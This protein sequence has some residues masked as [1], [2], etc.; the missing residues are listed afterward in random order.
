MGVC[1]DKA[2]RRVTRDGHGVAS[3]RH[4]RH[5]VNDLLA[6]FVLIQVCK[7]AGPAVGLAQLQRPPG[8]KA[9]RQELDDH[10]V[11]AHAIL[12]VSIFPGFA[13]RHADFFYMV[14]DIQK[15]SFSIGLLHRET[16][17]ASA[18]RVKVNPFRRADFFDG[19]GC[20]RQFLDVGNAV[21]IRGQGDF[22]LIVNNHPAIHSF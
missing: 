21:F 19:V 10:A 14:C 17:L 8:I 4:F 15:N 11:R 2:C 18:Q 13:D 20:N 16:Q 7:A 6:V 3:N 1:D 22:S 5:S 12:V 9:I